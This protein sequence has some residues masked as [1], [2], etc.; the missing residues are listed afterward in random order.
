MRETMPGLAAIVDRTGFELETMARM[1]SLAAKNLKVAQCRIKDIEAGAATRIDP[2]VL[3]RYVKMLGLGR[4][5]RR[6]AAVNRE[7]A[8]RVGLVR[9]RR[10]TGKGCVQ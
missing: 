9:E 1:M 4:W 8:E 2:E 6:W 5:V 7:V 10:R 3:G